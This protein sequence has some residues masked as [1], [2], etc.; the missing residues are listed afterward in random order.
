VLVVRT[1]AGDL[2]A[3]NLNKDIRHWSMAGYQWMRIQSPAHP[4][5]WATIKA[6]EADMMAMT[7]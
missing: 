6:P 7:W 5:F 1:R 3:D 2:V 4:M